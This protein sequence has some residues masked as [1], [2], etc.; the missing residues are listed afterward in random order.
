MSRFRQSVLIREPWS[1]ASTRSCASNGA[2]SRF[3]EGRPARDLRRQGPLY[4]KQ[5]VVLVL[6]RAGSAVIS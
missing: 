1:L 4:Q 6:V 3:G 5:A 2:A